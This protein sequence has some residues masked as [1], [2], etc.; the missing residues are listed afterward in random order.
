MTGFRFTRVLILVLILATALG[1]LSAAAT[2]VDPTGHWEGAIAI[3]GSPLNISVDLARGEDGA[4]S[5]S[6][7]IPQQGASDLAAAGVAVDGASV[8]FSIAGIPGE[9]SF[10][11]TLSDDGTRLEG[12]FTQ[13]GASFPF[14][15]ERATAPA[16]A[17]DAV[18][19]GL[20][21]MITKAL[22]DFKVPGLGLAVVVDGK[23][24]SA[25]GYGL[26]DIG[27]QLPVDEHTLFAIGSA[28]KAFTTC[29]LATLVDEGTLDWD[30]PVA[31]LIPGFRLEDDHATLH[32]TVRDMLSHRSGL[33]RHDLSWYG[34]TDAT[35]ADLVHSLRYLQP[36][37]DLRQDWH[38][39][40]LMY[41][42]AGYLGGQLT[43]GTWEEAV[44]TRLLDPLGMN[45]TNFS[46]ADSKLATDHAV[47]Y[48]EDDHELEAIA[49]RDIGPSGPAGAIN[50]SA[51]DM[52]RWLQ[53]QL[54]DGSVDGRRIVSEVAL[55]EMHTPQ[56]V[57][58]RYPDKTDT[59][60]PTYGLGWFIDA[61][62]GHY[63]VEH[64]G[65]IDGFSALVTLYPLDGVGIVALV[66]AEGSPVP[67]LVTRTLADRLLDLTP[68]PW[69]SE[70]LERRKKGEKATDEAEKKKES[71]RI[72]G[73]SPAHPLTDYAGEY[74]HPAY[75]T[76]TVALVDGHLEATLH[77]IA[78]PLEHWHYETFNGLKNFDDP[79]F[80]D[81]KFTFR[82]NPAGQADAVTAPLEPEADDIVFTRLPDRRL[83]DPEYL[84]R[85][86]GEYELAGETLTVSLQGDVLLITAP[87]QPPY[88]LEPRQGSE[89]GLKGVSV[90]TLHF[91]LDDTGQA[92]EVQLIQPNGVFTAK[93][94]TAEAEAKSDEE[95]ESEAPAKQ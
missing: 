19:A 79:T 21:P 34:V 5:G 85:F 1:A 73:T 20:E 18:I 59:L 89:F 49:F 4:W 15:L 47:P 82:T 24:V 65:N 40:N 91:T 69:F 14:N 26:R 72:K 36:Y 27:H 11:G 94:K 70:A 7:S 12:Q 68:K 45:E 63:E 88:E 39:Q 23:V 33:P 6:V 30:T 17:A 53:L 2:T 90:V 77:D 76:L 29:L 9:P 43:G 64:G 75:G 55:R 38:Y 25:R 44:Q 93:R 13:G 54:G 86:T 8:R 81:V 66:N 48:R 95:V 83:K 67:R 35:R 16:A 87:G 60:V 57:L 10:T 32:L 58:R 31:D 28:T 92:S 71:V 62:R 80:E 74:A 50:S 3:P 22:E 56:M 41:V 84:Q 46:V 51:A 37:R 42:T 78:T 52:A 61:Y